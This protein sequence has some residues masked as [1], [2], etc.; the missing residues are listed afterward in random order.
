MPSAAKDEIIDLTDIVEEGHPETPNLKTAKP[1]AATDETLDDL[2]LE[3]E[4]DQIFA[5]LGPPEKDGQGGASGKKGEPDSDTLDLDDLF[6]DKGDQ[7]PEASDQTDGMSAGEDSALDFGEDFEKLFDEDAQPK[8]KNER[9]SDAS[10]EAAPQSTDEPDWLA[11]LDGLGLDE[12]KPET[13]SAPTATSAD[14][15][16]DPSDAATADSEMKPDT[17]L[18]DVP[19][20]DPES[21]SEPETALETDLGTTDEVLEDV[22][23]ITEKTANEDPALDEASTPKAALPESV[24]QRLQEFEDRL[25]ALENR[26]SPQVDVPEPD[27]DGL[28]VQMDQRIDERVGSRV[29]SVQRTVDGMAEQ[30]ETAVA[31]LVDAELA[32]LSESMSAE[33][34]QRLKERLEESF[35][36]HLEKRLEEYKASIQEDIAQKLASSLDELKQDDGDQPEDPRI[37]ELA[38]GQD[39][40]RERIEELAQS[41]VAAS[42]PEENPDESLAS[43]LQERED[44]LEAR[45]LETIRQEMGSMREDWDGQKNA[46]AKD[47]EN[48]LNYWAKLQDKFKALQGEWQALRQEQESPRTGEQEADV[49]AFPDGW[50]DE[51][52]ALLDE[53]LGSLRTELR[54]ELTDEMDKAV[55]LAAARIIR[56]EIQ[57][58]SR[59]EEEAEQ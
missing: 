48:S 24:L 40:L 1:S 57:A 46:L 6:E 27:L 29:D 58:M 10:T 23:S 43:T 33:V 28:L 34:E 16:P 18:Q 55:P 11:E 56:E 13:A 5:D 41:Q 3:R 49:A 47:L 8:Q 53:R 59:E 19:E 50:R 36:E 51:L 4:I 44:H 42:A 54:R 15:S 2:D 22:A 17:D 35:A 25:A 37:A 32:K 20:T 52:T 38:A 7:A 26:E 31:K 45:L 14:V 12:A 39:A 21:G 9:D 30:T